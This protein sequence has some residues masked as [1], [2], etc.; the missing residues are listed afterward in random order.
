MIWHI[1]KRELYDNLNSLRF[2]LAT[3]LLIGLMITNAIVYLREYPARVQQYRNS[4]AESLK[5]LTA[6]TDLY[7]I[8]LNGPGMLYKQPVPL[9]FCA[10]G[11][12]SFLSEFVD[13]GFWM[14]SHGDGF[15]DF[16]M[17]NYPA[18]NPNLLNIR[19][20]VTKVDWVFVIGYVSSLL[21][22]LF[23]FDAVSGERE[24]GTLRLILA[25]SIPRHTVL[26]GKF[27]G[28]LISLCIPT[29]IAVLI[30]LLVIS[31]S[32]TVH[33]SSEAW[34]R[35]GIIIAV[36]LVYICLFLA[37]GLLVSTLT[38]RSSVSLVVLLLTWVIFVVFVPSSL[39]SIASGFSSPISFDELQ[40]RQNQ[41]HRALWDAYR[42]RTSG[43]ETLRRTQGRSEYILKQREQ[44]ER[45]RREHL[46]QQITQVQQARTV[47]R[48]SPTAI[49]QHSLEALTGTGFARHLQFLE[50]TQRYAREYR[51]FVENTDRSDPE[52]LHLIGVPEGMSKKPVNPEAIPKFEDTLTFSRDF[53]AATM[54]LLLLTLFVLVLL[55]AAYLAFVRV[56]V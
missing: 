40:K 18:S 41:R 32:S 4:V 17:L 8:A 20:D 14:W 15:K 2:V 30:N 7:D 52:S 42:D 19:P 45:S 24:R 54:D 22:L 37:L 44:Q 10:E 3:V 39:A 46:N 25:N 34:K 9:R 56:E 55:S 16:W 27:L 31:T 12:E 29:V 26:L 28:A 50:N 43:D 1:T 36:A 23:T 21:A 48:V 47:T 33:L 11:G 49:L 51:E 53:N 5:V 6:R 35:L 38:R 13:G